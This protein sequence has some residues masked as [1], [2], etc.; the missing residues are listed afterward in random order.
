MDLF[1]WSVYLES[2][3]AMDLAKWASKYLLVEGV[4]EK[5]KAPECE[6]SQLSKFQNLVGP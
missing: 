6:G 5:S 4:P 3:G 1:F 2:F